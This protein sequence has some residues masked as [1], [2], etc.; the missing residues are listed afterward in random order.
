MH[1]ALN[2]KAQ[3]SPPP[4]LKP[5][6]ENGEATRQ[7]YPEILSEIRVLVPKLGLSSEQE[8]QLREKLVHAR[9]ELSA[10][11]KNEF[12]YGAECATDELAKARKALRESQLEVQ[13]LEGKVKEERRT[14]RIEG[15][16]L[17]QQLLRSNG[18]A[19]VTCSLAQPSAPSASERLQASGYLAGSSVGD[20]GGSYAGGGAVP[21]NP[22]GVTLPDI[23]NGSRS[24]GSLFTNGRPARARP[25]VTSALVQRSCSST[26]LTVYGGSS[27]AG[28]SCTGGRGGDLISRLSRPTASS[29]AMNM[30]GGARQRV[31]GGSGATAPREAATGERGDW[32]PAGRT[33]LQG[34]VGRQTDDPCDDKGSGGLGTNGTAAAKAGGV[35]TGAAGEEAGVDS[36]SKPLNRISSRSELA[37]YIRYGYGVG[38]RE[39]PQVSKPGPTRAKLKKEKAEAEKRKKL[40]E[41]K[42]AEAAASKA[43]VEEEAAFDRRKVALE[44]IGAG[45]ISKAG[46]PAVAPPSSPTPLQG[47]GLE[48]LDEAE[49]HERR[50]KKSGTLVSDS[51]ASMRGAGGFD[52][53]GAAKAAQHAAQVKAEEEALAKATA[54]ALKNSG[55]PAAPALGGGG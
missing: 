12:A 18:G 1:A 39:R 8:K 20:A 45:R 43:D 27:A 49:Q 52:P 4:L 54:A 55:A 48:D 17:A 21:A 7:Q 13:K 47:R 5:M 37:E 26:L 40:E 36:E 19:C 11:L 53:D 15:E 28:P 6:P 22:G 51:V 32:R 46:A 31:G 16:I 30:E 14:R 38:K 35:G 42:R 34:E 23:G 33:R 41:A 9:G 3:A 2:R 50:N 29:A 44:F 24:T 25:D 10:R